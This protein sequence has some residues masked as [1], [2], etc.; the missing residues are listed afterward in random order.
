[1]KTFVD[2]LLEAGFKPDRS[3][4]NPKDNYFG[5]SV[6]DPIRVLSKGDKSCV[7]SVSSPNY[8]LVALVNGQEGVSASI[9]RADLIWINN[10]Y[11]SPL[12]PQSDSIYWIG[13]GQVPDEETVTAFIAL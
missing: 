2:Q 4:Y 5:A 8:R 9:G 7:I 3:D 10:K 11:G 1:M 13:L 6:Y 12:P